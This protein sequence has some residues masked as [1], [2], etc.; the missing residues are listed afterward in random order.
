MQIYRYIYFKNMKI[1]ELWFIYVHVYAFWKM[2]ACMFTMQ[3]SVYLLEKVWHAY[4][5]SVHLLS[6]SD[7]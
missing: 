4:Y 7:E 3:V 5:H 2:N 6:L 1:Y